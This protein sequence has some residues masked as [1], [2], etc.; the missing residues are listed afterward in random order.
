[1]TTTAQR[2]NIVSLIDQA[3]KSGARMLIACKQIGLACRTLQ[4]WLS[5]SAKPVSDA[6]APN[7]AHGL[8]STPQTLTTA[9]PECAPQTMLAGNKPVRADHRQAA[10]RQAVTPHN[11]LT[12]EECE[13]VLGVINSAEFKDLPPSQIVPRLAD[14]GCYMASESTMQRLLRSRCQSAHRRSERPA[15]KRYKPFALKATLVNQVYTW[16][17]TYLPTTIKGRYFYLYVFVDIFSRY[18][19][20]AQV[21]ESESADLAGDL[22]KNICERYGIEPGQVH[23]HSDNGSPMKGLTMQAMM[24]ELGVI[25]SR[26]RPSVSNDNP[27][28]E[29]L[30]RTLKYRPLMPVKPFESID[31]ARMWAIGLVDWYNQEHRHSAIRFVTPQ[32]RHCGEDALLLQ[33]RAEVY[34]HA[35]DQN[36]SRWSK[37]TR[38]WSRVTEVHLNPDKPD[39][40]EVKSTGN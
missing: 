40:K 13:A 23:L 22:L 20:G 38:N 7:R 35:R 18:I 2:Q 8:E 33:K 10:L 16:D 27:Y 3:C 25:A 29:S 30:F 28:S 12:P 24:H 17:I 15:K 1:M 39:F 6:L 14:Q 31:Q 26:S 19:V 37:N 36:P 4:R 32:Q 11:K 21:F 34:G 9:A 5:P